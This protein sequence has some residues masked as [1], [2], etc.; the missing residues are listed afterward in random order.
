MQIFAVLLFGCGLQSDNA[1]R[2]DKPDK[3]DYNSYKIL[4]WEA[5][6]SNDPKLVALF[7]K[8]KSRIAFDEE[9]PKGY[10]QDFQSI[11]R[12]DFEKMLIF[13]KTDVVNEAL[14]SLSYG[15][16]EYLLGSIGIR[17][18]SLLYDG[19]FKKAICHSLNE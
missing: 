7:L 4:A 8:V 10:P 16:I 6:N 2:K 9:Y 11:Y 13:N 14:K 5:A 12:S 19:S 1:T 3:G 18:A 15:E 17:D